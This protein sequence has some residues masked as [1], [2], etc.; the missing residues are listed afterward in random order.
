[1]TP[2]EVTLHSAIAGLER[3]LDQ[4]DAPVEVA[5]AP[6]ANAIT[7][8]NDLVWALVQ[9]GEYRAGSLEDS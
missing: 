6:F 1:M 4:P 2:I 7:S 5:L 9:Q 8:V 3:L